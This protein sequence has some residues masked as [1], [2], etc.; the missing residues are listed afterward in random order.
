MKNELDKDLKELLGA[1]RNAITVLRHNAEQLE[2]QGYD[3]S[4]ERE[5][6][7]QL[8][9]AIQLVEYD[10]YSAEELGDQWDWRKL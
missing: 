10:V 3:S 8:N 9:R 4:A 1:A 7:R 5:A 6:V 2:I